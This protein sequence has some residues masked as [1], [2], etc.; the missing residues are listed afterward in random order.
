LL[1]LVGDL[2][3]MSNAS[4]LFWPNLIHLTS[5]TLNLRFFSGNLHSVY[6]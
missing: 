1:H 2:F 3:K 5:L 6:W 4:H